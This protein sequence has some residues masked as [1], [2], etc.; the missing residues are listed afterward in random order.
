MNTFNI[1]QNQREIIVRPTIWAC[2]F[3][4]KLTIDKKYIKKGCYISDKNHQVEVHR[5]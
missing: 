5:R 2:I 4:N 1:T 3:G